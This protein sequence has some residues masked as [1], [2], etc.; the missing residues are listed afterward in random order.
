M[1]PL[2]RLHADYATQSLTPGPHPM[3][4]WREKN[5]LS[6]QRPALGAP[7][8]ASELDAIPNNALITIA[9]QV[10]CRQR[11]GTA[12]GHMF[13]SLEDET[14]VSNAFVPSP[15]FEKLRLVIT[16]EPFLFI[17]G[18]LQKE[19]Q[20]SMTVYAY[21]IRPLQFEAALET[22]SHDFH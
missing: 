16:Q 19:V 20:R 12:K 15:L 4:Y 17:R 18:R 2:E 9:G 21:D 3:A 11:P 22:R 5:A 6:A 7:L 8:R 10:I 13:I 1:T 14:G